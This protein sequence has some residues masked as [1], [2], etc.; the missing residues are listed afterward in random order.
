MCCD[1]SQARGDIRQ[2]GVVSFPLKAVQMG[3]P[4][5]R[6][7]DVTSALRYSIQIA[8]DLH[9]ADYARR[10]VSSALRACSV[11]DGVRADVI[12]LVS[13]LISNVVRHEAACVID[14]E[15][16]MDGAGAVT[17]NVTGGVADVSARL[18]YPAGLPPASRRGGR[19]LFILD[20]VASAWG[21]GRTN[22]RT[23]VWFTVSDGARSSASTSNVAA[24]GR[25]AELSP[26]SPDETQLDEAAVDEAVAVV[27]ATAA[28]LT[29]EP[30]VVAT[31]AAVTAE[32]AAVDAATKTAAAAR[33]AR[34]ARAA[35]AIAAAAAVAEAAART[36]DAVQAQADELAVAVASAAAEAAATV[37][38]SMVV[39]G[40]AEAARV[41]RQVG[42]MV[43]S[44]A[45][46]KAEETAQAALLVARAVAAAAAAVASTT[47][48]AAA[49]M[50]DEVL[51]AAVAVRA[52]TA[53]AA[54]ELA[55]DT[56]ERGAAV[57]LATREA[58]A[59]SDAASE[60]L[61]EA[62]RQLERAGVHDRIVA[63]A[64][65]EAMLTR[66][67]EPAGL[68]LAARYLTAAEQDQ[69]GGDWYDAIEL[70]TGVTTLVIGDVIGHDIRAAATM[71][72]LRNILRAQLLERND[73]PS[74]VVTRLDGA[75]RDLHIDTIAT[76]ILANIEPPSA[77][78]RGS[79]ATLRWSNAGHPAPILIHADGSAIQLDDTT[80]L[81]LG[82][83]PNC[84]RRDH[85][86]PIPPGATLLLYTDGLVETRTDGIDVGQRRLLESARRH[87]RCQP[88][89]L[90]DAVLTDMVGDRP[91]DDVAVLAVRFQQTL[92]RFR[93]ISRDSA[94]RARQNGAS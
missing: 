52:V 14:V 59:A 92:T 86:F 68:L 66:L 34:G 25:S 73:P 36:V 55:A 31:W 50:E 35:A 2:C 72:Q 47:A 22:G 45:V 80:D 63:L 81:L 19:G 78:E 38:N 57:A 94:P 3:R 46:A 28:R 70:P 41:A 58:V 44:T 61:H 1:R 16:A 88:G 12:L 62:N 24:A 10:E 89:D 64:L 65:Q 75:I 6:A 51:G 60:R 79:V 13:E 40:D 83:A 4:S 17:V 30:E 23:S 84:N 32:Q 20:S 82:F 87:H 29:A 11:G 33:E 42:A 91:G 21:T 56:V 9:A 71:G 85:S 53:A 7:N 74:D 54:R 5:E 76:M 49:A 77:A 90:L 15:V 43:L 18:V 69:V 67:P 27:A 39:G 48:A 93:P 8:A 37:S 26:A